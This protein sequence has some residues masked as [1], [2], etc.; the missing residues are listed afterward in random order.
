MLS[1][2]QVVLFLSC[3]PLA[4]ALPCCGWRPPEA[5]L[6]IA[7]HAWPGYEPMFLARTQGWLK[8]GQVRLLETSSATDSLKALA[9]GRVDG[10]ALTL[11]EV[12][13]ARGN[14]L[15]LSVVAVLDI[16]AGAD[17]VVARPTLKGLADLKGRRLGFEPGAVGELM[18]VH[19]LQAANLAREDVTLISLPVDQHLAAWRKNQ[20]DAAVTYEPM[21]SQLLAQGAIKLF[22]S[23]QLPNTIVDVLTIRGDRLDRIHAGAIRHLLQAHFRALE[24]LRKNPQDAAYRMAPRLQVSAADFLSLFKGLVLPDAANNH[25]LLAGDRPA[26]MESAHTLCTSM[27]KSGLLAQDDPLTGLIRADFLPPDFH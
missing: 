12:L 11:D 4:L 20:I 15:P 16:S 3:T 5:P 1:R 8:V 24:Y 23:R 7:A 25:R 17:M 21:A 14:G 9:D 10:A 27:V 22:D 13:K 2:R 18:L 26:L 6:A 19:A